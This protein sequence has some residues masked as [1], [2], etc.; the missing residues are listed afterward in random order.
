[1]NRSIGLA[2]G[3]AALLGAPPSMA[4]SP[5][6]DTVT[7][8]ALGPTAFGETGAG[9][10]AGLWR[11]GLVLETSTRWPL[12]ESAGIGTRLAWGLTEWD[13]FTAFT[14]AGYA[15]GRWTTHAYRDVWHFASADTEQ[16][17]RAMGGFF[18]F[19]FLLFPYMVAGTAYVLAP[20]ATTTYLELDVTGTYD[21]G[22]A[23]DEV[24][25][26]LGAGVGFAAWLHPR[27]DEPYGGL[28]P[29]LA[30]GLRFERLDLALKGTWFPP[31]AH[32]EAGSGLTSVVTSALTVGFHD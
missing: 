13:R 28:G 8:F 32:G 23:S 9:S 4:A 11:P 3:V 31:Y 16:P 29:T 2:A 27:T 21:F 19:A 22:D 25:P 18:G 7:T 1:M 15:I 30:L 12:G 6:R 14:D 26:Y 24:V 10:G 17:F 5:E 20:F